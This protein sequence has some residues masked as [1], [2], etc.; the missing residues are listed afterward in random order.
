MGVL[1]GAGARVVIG[2][3][4]S[5]NWGRFLRYLHGPLRQGHPSLNGEAKTANASAALRPLG[6][7]HLRGA[8]CV[9]IWPRSYYAR[10]VDV[11][12][13]GRDPQHESGVW[14]GLS[15]PGSDDHQWIDPCRAPRAAGTR[16]CPHD[17]CQGSRSRSAGGASSSVSHASFRCI[18]GFHAA[19]PI[20]PP[21]YSSLAGPSD[22]I[23][24]FLPAP[25]ANP[26]PC[27]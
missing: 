23:S 1:F 21:I 15:T 9:H 24:R 7:V 4:R 25:S 20:R 13:V 14:S 18:V 16:A 11:I 3:H 12:V 17:S 6:N 27:C 19:C 10:G 5:L 26:P 8:L 2:P 22:P